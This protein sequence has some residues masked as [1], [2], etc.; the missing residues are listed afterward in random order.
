MITRREML[1]RIVKARAEKIP[2]TNYGLAVSVLQGVVERTLSPFPA[3]LAA[4]QNELAK[5]PHF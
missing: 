5:N 2:I 3:A 1:A 4:Y